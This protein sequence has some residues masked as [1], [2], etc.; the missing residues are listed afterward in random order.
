MSEAM[1]WPHVPERLRRLVELAYNLWWSWHPE[2]RELFRRLDYALWNRVYH[3][4]VKLLKEI[5]PEKLTAAAQDPA[6]RR[7]YEA[8]LKAFDADMRTTETWF[9]KR[10]PELGRCPVAYFSF[11]FGLHNSLPVYAGGLG[12]LAGDHCKEASDLGLPLVGVGFMYPQGYVHQHLSPEGWQESIYE[13]ID[14]SQVPVQEARLPSG[15]ACVIDVPLNGR[16]I[17]VTVWQ[18]QVGRVPLYLL[19]TNVQDNEPWERELSARLYG[20]D[21]E[22]RLQQEMVLG[23]G[24]VRVLRALGIKPAAWHINEGHGAVVMLERIREFV[25]QGLSF[26][27]AVDI[28]R[29]TTI[30]TTHTPVPA[31]HDA[32]PFELVQ[33]HFSHYWASLG[34]TRDEFLRLG[35]HQEPWGPAFNM[36]V[37]ALRLAGF[38]NGV[39][40]LH[41]QTTRRMWHVLWP[42]VPEEQVPV[43]SIT[44]GI[45]VPTWIA[46]E[47]DRLY[48]K[49]L[50]PRW[51]ERHDDPAL[52]QLILEIPED[53][54]WAVHQHLKRKLMSFIRE[55]ARWQWIRGEV[56]PEQVLAA[57]T[58]L[59]P[60]ALTIGFARR[61]ATYKRADLIFRDPDRLKRLLQDPWRPVQI[62]FAGKAHPADEPAQRLIQQV[63]RLA[64]DHGLGGQIAFVEDYDMHVA[65]Y[66][67][68]GVDVWLNTPRRPREASGTSG[69]KAILNGVPHLSILDGWWHEAYNGANGWA[70]GGDHDQEDPAA[71]DNQEA[72]ALYQ[73]LEEE[74]I[75]LYYDRD[76]DGVPRGWMRIVKEAIASCVPRFSARRMVKEYVERM[77]VP[78]ARS[79]MAFQFGGERE[80][81]VSL[82][83]E[84]ERKE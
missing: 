53:E 32:F 81:S 55:R 29:S 8:V 38:R 21:Q 75:P 80:M 74:V 16:D 66:V 40:Q 10:Y 46:P 68:Q 2:A 19:D 57:G 28:V 4:P 78:A 14:Y 17:R 22:L 31:G 18:V 6:F 9:A 58:L 47:V 59:D 82:R 62:I 3:N 13:H 27:E 43:T 56:R 23:I 48:N 73:L 33:A 11:E 50:G 72:H 52:W 42:D 63:Y 61:F 37:L 76:R 83:H 36:T 15:Q 7:H 65:H 20:G 54:L 70:I 77:Y 30:F 25:E 79:L 64:K 26:A 1:R 71:Q 60:E 34:L 69:Q 35:A 5:A 12:I 84:R 41:G 51:V 24:G 49:Y 67:V 39:S 45:H 44:N